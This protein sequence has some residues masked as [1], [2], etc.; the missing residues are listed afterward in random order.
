MLPFV[1]IVSSK[2]KIETK[3]KWA[4]SF[5]TT[6]FLCLASTCSVTPPSPSLW[7]IEILNQLPALSTIWGLLKCLIV[8]ALCCKT[9]FHPTHYLI[10]IDSFTHQDKSCSSTTLIIFHR[11]VR[12]SFVCC[13]T[14]VLYPDVPPPN[15][16]PTQPT[17]V[18]VWL[19][20]KFKIPAQSEDKV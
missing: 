5:S 11:F 3:T 19:G 13:H 16:N 17:E 15:P 20:H 4:Q 10:F 9:L 6:T 1:N 18:L 14:E 12:V 7:W 2:S 8:V